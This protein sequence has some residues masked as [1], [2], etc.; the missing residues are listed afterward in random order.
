MLSMEGGG[1]EGRGGGGD[2]MV[3]LEVKGG[4]IGGKGRRGRGMNEL[5]GVQQL[6]RKETSNLFCHNLVSPHVV[7][8]V[9]RISK[10]DSRWRS[11]VV[12]STRSSA[13]MSKRAESSSS[14]S[15][16]RMRL[17]PRR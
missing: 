11:L 10:A 9:T 8:M 12:R 6:L 17:P 7:A 3:G 2:W 16:A 1:L 5:H 14:S 13:Y 4:G 15:G